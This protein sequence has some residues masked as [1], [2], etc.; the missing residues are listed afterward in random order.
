[1]LTIAQISDLHITSDKDPLNQ[2]R[3]EQRLRAVF[4]AIHA[5]RPRPIAIV[6]SGD[7]VDRGEPE[8]YR[9]LRKIL[10]DAQIAVHLGVGNHDARGPF[11]AAFP[12]TPVDDNGFVQYSADLGGVRLIMCDTLEEGSD[13][14]AF[15][16]TRA[17]WLKRELDRHRDEPTIVAL[18]HPP[19]LS[20]IQWMDPDPEAAWIERLAETLRGCPQVRAVIAGHVHR[21]FHGA[22]AGHI[23]SVSPATSIQLTLDLTAVNRR[24]PD[25]REILLE[26]PPGYSLLTW[27]KGRLT[28][29]VCVAGDYPTAVTYDVP[30][31]KP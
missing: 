1:M 5:L 2:A 26:E 24:V 7:L 16:E 20:G 6:A 17:N 29:H 30:F 9:E 27:D 31:V 23:V 25:G 10:A 4:R 28:T 15:C 18:H 3:N 8:E 22:F 21:G 11:R 19:I 14:G 12:K 13:Q